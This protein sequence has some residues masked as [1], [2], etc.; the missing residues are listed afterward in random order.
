V[1][2][3]GTSGNAA[4]FELRDSDP[5]WPS[6]TSIQ[7]SEL[8]SV[9]QQTFNQSGINV[10]DVRWFSTRLYLPYTATEKFEW[11]HGGSNAFTD[12]MDLHP[13]SGS[14][15]PAL[16]LEWYGGSK[17]EWATLRVSGGD[18]SNPNQYADSIPMWQ[19]TDASGNRVM[20]NFN[21]WIDIVWGMRFA[22]DSTGW[23]EVW[24][25]G[26]NIYPRKNRPT[27]WA[28]DAAEY[29]KFGLYKQKDAS[30]PETGRSVIY[31]GPTT[32]GYS[33]P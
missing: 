21:R 19:L 27:M 18:F 12:I 10:G 1:S 33:K 2:A 3:P 4:R 17:N 31:F 24:V 23:L 7:K 9:T 11:A 5:G 26:A 16:S 22:S 25:D 14:M 32:I 28:G 29:F 6:N 8:R 30:F 15:W 13:G 20:S